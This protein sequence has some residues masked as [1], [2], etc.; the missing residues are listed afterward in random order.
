MKRISLISLILALCI[1]LC[2]FSSCSKQESE[3][4]VPNGM[5]LASGDVD[6]YM[7]VPEAWKVD[8]SD[9]YTSAT[10]SS[11]DPTSISATAYAVSNNI[12]SVSDW[13]SNG[14]NG[15]YEEMSLVYTDISEI[16]E[17]EATLGGIEGTEYSFT[18]KLA[19]KEYCFVIT[20]VFNNFYIY[21]ITYT[22]VPEYNENHTADREQIIEAFKFKD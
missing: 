16:S 13:W 14:E 19:D 11:G 7:F 2:T 10:F 22:S 6:Y 4:E 1:C 17:T 21:Y 8:R 20:A 18:A 12:Q 3:V 5:K 15:F 9:L